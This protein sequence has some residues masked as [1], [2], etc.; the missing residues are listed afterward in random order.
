DLLDHE[1]AGDIEQRRGLLRRQLE[2]LRH[3]PKWPRSRYCQPWI[4]HCSTVEQ[5]LQGRADNHNSSPANGDALDRMRRC[6]DFRLTFRH[7]RAIMY[8]RSTCR[9]SQCLTVLSHTT[10]SRLSPH[11]ESWKPVLS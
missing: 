2:F 7:I 6:V 11:R 1:G 8:A 3:E 10:H 9:D 4:R 5:L